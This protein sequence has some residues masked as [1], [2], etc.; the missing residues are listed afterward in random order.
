LKGGVEGAFLDL[1]HLARFALDR[2][3]DLKAVQLASGGD[4]LEDEHVERA[5]RDRR[6]GRSRS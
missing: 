5:G 4:G 6:A 2:L 1:E 3:G